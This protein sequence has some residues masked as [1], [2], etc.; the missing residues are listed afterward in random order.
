MKQSIFLMLLTTVTVVNSEIFNHGALFDQAKI[1]DVGNGMNDILKSDTK[2][3]DPTGGKLLNDS[4]FSSPSNISR[5][6]NTEEVCRCWDAKFDL[7][8]ELECSCEGTSLYR[9]PQKLPQGLVRLTITSSPIE[10]IR[11]FGLKIYNSS[12]KDLI[13]TNL[14]DFQGIREGAFENL[15]VLRKIYISNAPKLTF[16]SKEVFRGISSTIK[17]IRIIHCGLVRVP[18]MQLLPPYSILQMIDLEGNKIDR[19]QSSTVNVKTE[20][21]ILDNNQLVDIEESAFSGSHIE[22]LSIKSNFLLQRIHPSAF[23]GVKI[24]DLD[25]SSTSLISLPYE[26]LHEIEKLRIQNTHT[27]KTIPSIYKFNNLKYAQLTHPFHCCAFKFP[28][29]HDKKLHDEKLRELARI[30][31]QCKNYTDDED[32]RKKRNLDI[33]TFNETD[34]LEFFEYITMYNGEDAE[35]DEMNSD[36]GTF[37][38]PVENLTGTDAICG[39]ITRIADVICTPEP[40]DLNP[41]EDVMGSDWLRISV[42]V[43]AFFSVIGN[44]IVLIWILCTLSDNYAVPKFLMCHLAIADLCTGLYLLLIASMDVHSI[45]EYFNY[46]YDW[47]YGPGCKVAGFLTVFASHLSVFTLTIITI[48]RWFAITNA[49]YLNKRINMKAA[50]II[51]AGGWIYSIIMSTFP[52][53]GVSNYSST[54]IC[55]PME[56]RDISDII[57]LIAIIGINGLAFLIIAVCYSQIYYSLASETRRAHHG[58]SGESSVAKKMALLV[59]TNFT[60]WAPIAFFGLTALAGF[61]LINVTNSK[62]LLVFFYP[63]N[64]CADPYLYAIL[65]QQFRQ[66]FYS[67]IAKLG[68]C[69]ERAHRYK[70]SGSN[71]HTTTLQTNSLRRNTPS[72]NFNYHSKSNEIQLL[73]EDFV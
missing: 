25:L 27:L 66:D 49:M 55:L 63:M 14:E 58:Q 53:Y 5:S 61:P 1:I 29:R 28:S 26:G 38:T 45:G 23:K 71:L 34:A 10:Q 17:T 9:V 64:S 73:N 21:F 48:E 6:N 36:F 41:C 47:Q 56:A 40:D 30:K 42:W 51:M 33:S 4:S 12:L 44:C 39:S 59:F 20:Q 11:T 69:E 22:K 16:L 13:L 60:C 67:F 68:L 18:D 35:D 32:E 37:H 19:I 65:T 15:T 2:H 7:N 72:P 46:A 50:S 57:Y 62:I 54:S 52:L 3:L 31:E 70:G 8:S 24:Q 43:V